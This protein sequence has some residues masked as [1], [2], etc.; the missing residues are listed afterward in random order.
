MKTQNY[1]KNTQSAKNHLIKTGEIERFH[2]NLKN[3]SKMHEIDSDIFNKGKHTHQLYFCGMVLCIASRILIII[4][5]G[6]EVETFDLTT[7]CIPYLRFA[8]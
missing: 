5:L 2:I 1:L 6:I 7:P 3:K 4:P 8:F